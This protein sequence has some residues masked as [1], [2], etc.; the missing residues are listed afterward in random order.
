M[1]TL[2]RPARRLTTAAAAL[3][4]G[5]RPDARRVQRRRQRGL[6]RRRP[7]RA[8]HARPDMAAGGDESARRRRWSAAHRPRPAQAPGAGAAAVAPAVLDR[9]LAAAPTSRS[10]STTSTSRPPGCASIAASAEGLVLAEAISSEPDATATS[11]GFSTITIS[12][13]T[14]APRRHPRPLAKLGKVHSRNASHRRRHRAVRRHR[15]A[16]QDD[17]VQRRA[18]PRADEP[19]HQARRRRGA[20]GRAVP[21]PG[22]PRGDADPARRPRR[23]R[24]RWRRSR[25]G[26]APTREVLA[27]GRRRHRVPRRARRRM[28]APSRLRD[29]CCSPCSARSSRSPWS[30]PS[31]ASRSSSGCGVAARA[32]AAPP[33]PPCAAR[34]RPPEPHPRRSP[35]QSCS[36]TQSSTRSRNAVGLLHRRQVGRVGPVDAAHPWRRPATRVPAARCAMS[37]S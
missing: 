29:A 21:P 8:R 17:A 30:R 27:A 10:P 1:R 24:W 19:G 14:D 36:A 6:R 22:R 7:E 25:C 12:V 15:V 31:C 3:V 23:T 34:R 16:R 5:A 35:R 26:S 13:P 37:R 11:G 18:G 2:A 32:R 28:G 20:R 33:A 4:L 9:K